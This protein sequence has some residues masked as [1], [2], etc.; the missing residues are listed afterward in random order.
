MEIK[1]YEN[2]LSNY[3]DILTFEET[4]RILQIGKHTCYN[5]L[6]TKQ[7][8]SK[9]IAGKYRIPKAEIIEFLTK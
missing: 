2:I 4:R 9:K 5:L 8:Y 3:G 7:I 1:E 6:K